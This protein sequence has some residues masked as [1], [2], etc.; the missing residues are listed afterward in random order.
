MTWYLFHCKNLECDTFFEVEGSMK[1]PPKRRKCPVC[2]K[3]GKREFTP[4]AIKTLKILRAKSE[5]YAKYG[6]D[7][8]EANEFLNTELKYSKERQKTGW[9]HYKRVDP[10]VENMIKSGAIKKLT[11]EQAEKKKQTMIDMTKEARKRVPPSPHPQT[12]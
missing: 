5:R 1:K 6:M 12:I 2:N 8:A 9:Q 7:K 11:P 3:F 4:P 10:N